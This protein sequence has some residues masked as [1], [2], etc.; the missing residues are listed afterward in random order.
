MKITIHRGANQIGGCVTEIATENSKI[1][2]DLGSN[3]PGNE[4]PDFTK[5]EVV[6]LCKGADAI[7]YTHYHGDHIGYIAEVPNEVEQ[8]IGEAAKEVMLC[9]YETLNAHQDWRTTICA[10]EK[11]K[12]YLDISTITM[13]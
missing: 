4:T 3:L 12:Y 2:I 5:E 6:S 8:Y 7:F 9:K 13:V 11:M 1:L 10:I